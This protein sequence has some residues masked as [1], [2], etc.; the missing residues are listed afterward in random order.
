MARDS[1]STLAIS[2]QWDRL[3]STSGLL[4]QQRLCAARCVP[5]FWPNLGRSRRSVVTQSKENSA[6]R[7]LRVSGNISTNP[8]INSLM[9]PPFRQ[10]SWQWHIW[11]SLGGASIAD[12]VGS[13]KG[14]VRLLC[15]SFA[16]G[17]ASGDTET[18]RLLRLHAGDLLE[19][20]LWEQMTS[21]QQQVPR[22]HSKR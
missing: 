4:H 21:L 16:L 11:F 10:R 3:I 18:V 2:S 7:S 8:C 15:H 20:S 1:V 22:E 12:Q 9:T 17:S 14:C 6:M 19:R 5:G 13:L